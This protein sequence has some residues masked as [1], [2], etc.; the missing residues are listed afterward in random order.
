MITEIRKR[1]LI[2]AAKKFMVAYFSDGEERSPSDFDE[3]IIG[4]LDVD[5]VFTMKP[6]RWNNTPFFDAM[7]ELVDDGIIKFRLT[8]KDEYVYWMPKQFPDS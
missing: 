4:G 2:D 6:P 8:L 5:C 3:D 1:L 7:G